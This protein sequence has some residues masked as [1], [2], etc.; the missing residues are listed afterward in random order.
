MKKYLLL[1]IIPFL[2]IGQDTNYDPDIDVHYTRYLVAP[3]DYKGDY[4]CSYSWQDKLGHNVLIISG[5][6]VWNR[7]NGTWDEFGLNM[8]IQS[9][10]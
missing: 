9:D 8:E 1:L 3:F 2:I 4:S 7:G 10:F 6:Q 5:E